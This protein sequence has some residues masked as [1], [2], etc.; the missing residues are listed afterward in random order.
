MI[1]GAPVETSQIL[2]ERNSA[3]ARPLSRLFKLNFWGDL[4]DDTH[5]VLAIYVTLMMTLFLGTGILAVDFGRMAVLRTQMQNAAD[6]AATAAAARLNGIPGSRNNATTAA[7]AFTANSSL[8]TGS[9]D[10]AVQ[11]LSFF[12]AFD[13][14]TGIGV[15]ATEDADAV[16][17]QV[18]I[19]PQV[20]DLILAPLIDLLNPPTGPAPTNAQLSAVATARFAPIICNATPFMVCDPAEG[21]DTS[22]SLSSI[23]NIGKQ[24]LIKQA[25]GGGS[26]APGQFGLL[27]TAGGDCGASDIGDALASE[28]DG[29]CTATEEGD[30]ETAPGAKTNQIRDGVNARFDIVTGQSPA[31]NIGVYPR[32]TSIAD[33]SSVFM[34][35]GVYDVDAYWSAKHSGDS[36]PVDLSGASRYQ[37][38][39]YELGEVYARNGLQTRYPINGAL[40]AGFTVITPPATD[41]PTGGA[42]SST[43]STNIK[44][45]VVQVAVLR[46]IAQDVKGSGTFSTN[47]RYVETF[48]TEGMPNVKDDLFGEIIN[49]INESNSANFH[50]NVF[51]LN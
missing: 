27:C 42:P 14:D 38:Y 31:Q 25:G 4:R 30:V 51:L 45:R 47:G 7:N 3:T 34:G 43:P 18:T 13:A 28:L 21:G 11:T 37:I 15:A 24:L 49:P 26:L 35:N 39:L 46:C 23:G 22:L 33:G 9:G 36:L 10:L 48:V 40:P 1:R 19:T 5:G 20:I 6:A 41:L 12:S 32:D 29:A 44:R 2:L 16:I 8:P 50:A 17:V